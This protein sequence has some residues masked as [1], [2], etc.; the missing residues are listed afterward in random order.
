[1]VNSRYSNGLNIVTGD[2]CYGDGHNLLLA[3]CIVDFYGDLLNNRYGNGL[4]W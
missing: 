2:S 3:V 1:M 4:N